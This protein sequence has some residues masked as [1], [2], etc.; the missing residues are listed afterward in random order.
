MQ[1]EL[2]NVERIARC[3]SRLAQLTEQGPPETTAD[4]A[5]VL[6]INLSVNFNIHTWPD[7]RNQTKKSTVTTDL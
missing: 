7:V 3:L 1:G 4:R 2:R 5:D 6:A